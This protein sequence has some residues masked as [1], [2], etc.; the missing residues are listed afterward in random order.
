MDADT[1]DS[2]LSAQFDILEM[3]IVGHYEPQ[4]KCWFKDNKLPTRSDDDS[5]PANLVVSS[6]LS[7]GVISTPLLTTIADRLD[8]SPLLSLKISSH[9]VLEEDALALFK[10]LTNLDT[11]TIC[12]NYGTLS[13]FLKE[14]QQQGSDASSPSFP[15]LRSVHLREIDF[16]ESRTGKADNAVRALITAFED[17][18]ASHPI[19][20]LTITQCVN[21]SEAHWRDLCTSSIPEDVD[22]DWDED[23]DIRQSEEDID[24][25]YTYTYTYDYT[26]TYTYD[27]TYTYTYDHDY[28]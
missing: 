22:M 20:R 9:D 24:Y 12:G 26:Y 15:A 16:D 14:F 10:N 4:I 28:D 18:E 2:S 8:I 11:I 27:Y 7:D 21:F 17:R 1:N 5:P 13:K 6:K 25:N 3:Q 23:E 19:E